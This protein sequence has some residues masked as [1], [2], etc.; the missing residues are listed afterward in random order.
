MTVGDHNIYIIRYKA[1][2]EKITDKVS[3]LL[4]AAVALCVC[5]ACEDTVRE[6]AGAGS[7]MTPG[8]VSLVPGAL[9]GPMAVVDDTP[10]AG[11][12][13]TKQGVTFVEGDTIGFF[14]DGGNPDGEADEKGFSNLKLTFEPP[15]FNS[16]E[17]VKD[18]NMLGRYFGYFPY[19]EGIE[20]PE[21]AS[22]Y[23]QD[24]D[25]IRTIDFLTT[26]YSGSGDQILQGGNTTWNG[27]YH[28]FAV[29]R[30]KCGEGF[31]E[32]DRA[33]VKVFLQMKRKVSAIRINWKGRKYEDS[34]FTA[35]ELVY[36]SLAVGEEERRLQAFR[37][38]QEGVGW[39]VIV[40]CIPM[41]WRDKDDAEAGGVT[42]DAIVFVSGTDTVEVPVDN[43]EVFHGTLNDGTV[44]LGV[45]GGFLYTAVVKKVGLEPTVYPY[46]VDEWREEDIA[47]TLTA[48]IG[49]EGDYTKFV[50]EYNSLFKEDKDYSTEEIRE[51]V[52]KSETLKQYGTEVKDGEE[53]AGTFTF[54]LTSDL[55]FSHTETPPCIKNLVIP[56][57]GRGYT[58]SNMRATGGFCGS[59]RSTLKNLRFEDISVTRPAGNTAPT[60]LLA[61]SMATGARI[62]GCTANGRLAG[63]GPVGAAAGTM[64]AGIVTGCSF[65][66]MMM[67]TE[68]DEEHGGLVGVF[69]GG[70]A[71]A[72]NNRNS[73]TFI[74]VVKE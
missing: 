26:N 10:P 46:D 33:D 44:V 67:G 31:T 20:E 47:D 24:G 42:V 59:L 13:H 35:V 29:V 36:D 52:E 41:M 56:F 55:D 54:L 28:T 6:A 32:Y 9:Q 37:H 48:G 30:V 38:E 49:S 3:G 4:A 34:P 23:E 64:S 22:V 71:S 70:T 2:M 43:K 40:P 73:M 39:D 21:G 8:R 25:T 16:D 17:Y 74:E 14:S 7:G 66:G 51:I 15:T 45:R 58:I 62:E 18:L 72:D 5:A 19:R 12:L 27:F 68:T 63:H 69:T 1:N 60:G 57:D 65:T 11:A 61:D 53:G 50:S